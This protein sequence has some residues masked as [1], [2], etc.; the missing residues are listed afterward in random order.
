[1]TQSMKDNISKTKAGVS[2]GCKKCTEKSIMNPLT[3]KFDALEKQIQNLTSFIKEEVISQLNEIKTDLA[4]TLSRNNK[5][6]E[7]TASKLTHLERENNNL[8]KQLNR[9]D[10]IVTG[11]SNNLKTDELYAAAIA[12]GKV[13]N[14]PLSEFDVNFCTYIK[15]KTAVL[16]KLN[17]VLKRDIIMKNYRETYNLKLNQVIATD[18]ESRVFLNDHYIP[19]V[20]KLQ[21]LCRKKKRSGEIIRFKVR[22]FEPFLFKMTYKNNKEVKMSCTEFL[23]SVSS[24][25]ISSGDKDL[26]NSTLDLQQTSSYTQEPVACGKSR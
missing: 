26:G 10:I 23:K 20:A 12:I 14:V 19:I 24:Q 11:L 7:D 22:N 18:I 1:M 17:S 6:E 25:Q 5:F 3:N 21:Y 9:A 15:H 2:F 16:I 8:Q 4:K 13:C